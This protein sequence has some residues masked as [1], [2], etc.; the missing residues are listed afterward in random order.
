MKG[1]S[2]LL[3]LLAI[4]AIMMGGWIFTSFSQLRV[5]ENNVMKIMLTKIG[6][7]LD[8]IKGFSRNALILATNEGTFAVGGEGI[9]FYCNDP[10]PPTTR[11]MRYE[12]SSQT[13]KLLNEYLKNYPASDQLAT[14]DIQNF[15][16]VDT[17]VEG[18]EQG[19]NDEN[20]TVNAYESKV[21]ISVKENNVSSSNE[22][23]EIIPENRFWF[24]YRKLRDWSY[25]EGLI[26]EKRVCN[27][28]TNIFP[29]SCRSMSKCTDCPEFNE[30]FKTAID[31]TAKDMEIFIND[32]NV[33]CSGEPT[34]CYGKKDPCLS[35]TEDQCG[36]WQT[37]EGCS[38]CTSLPD[39]ELCIENIS[40]SSKDYKNYREKDTLSFEGETEKY[41]SLSRIS[42]SPDEICGGTC[43]YYEAGYVNVKAQFTC[44]DKKY[45]LSLPF[46]EDRYLKFTIDTKISLQNKRINYID[47]IPC[48]GT[49]PNCECTSEY[50]GEPHCEVIVV[51]TV[52]PGPT[53]TP[54]TGPPTTAPPV[55]TE[56]YTT[57]PR[58][59]IPRPPN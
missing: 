16:C 37:G 4:M 30:C 26:F 29:K 48:G 31:N 1:Q 25:Q 43:E 2:S 17:P 57:V 15:S 3:I 10:T 7:Y 8:V 56:P 19:L 54:T 13:I 41:S 46:P 28:L 38:K 24:L 21:S 36:V 53:T 12:L 6:E 18:L 33:Q 39:K 27:C 34:C 14:I 5:Q 49:A 40:A 35:K 22:I 11:Q 47:T 52:P 23:F 32:S 20:F 44:T 51:T 9:T 42:F 58:T 50:C 55:T 45:L 59:T